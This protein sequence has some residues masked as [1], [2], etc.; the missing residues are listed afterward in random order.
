MLGNRKVIRPCLQPGSG[1]SGAANVEARTQWGL[2]YWRAVKASKSIGYR[3]GSRTLDVQVILRNPLKI[4]NKRNLVRL[5]TNQGVV[6]SNPAGRTKLLQEIRHLREIAGAFFSCVV[7]QI[8]SR[9]SLRP[10]PVDPSGDR[11]VGMDEQ[12]AGQAVAPWERSSIDA[13]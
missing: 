11:R 8:R 1:S 2:Y 12:L 13:L 10:A 6:G 9:D 5:A 7:P 4:K 3:R